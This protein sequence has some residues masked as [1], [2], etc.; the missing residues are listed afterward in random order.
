MSFLH[1]PAFV[2]QPAGTGKIYLEAS[3]EMTIPDVG[4]TYLLIDVFNTF[5]K[6]KTKVTK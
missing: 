1:K 6:N 5:A 3:M 2:I 4:I